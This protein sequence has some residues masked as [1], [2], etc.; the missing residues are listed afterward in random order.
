MIDAYSRCINLREVA[1]RSNRA[2]LPSLLLLSLRCHCSHHS[3]LHPL[4]Q[5]L[6]HLHHSGRSQSPPPANVHLRGPYLRAPPRPQRPRRHHVRQTPLRASGAGAGGLQGPQ[7]VS[8]CL[9]WNPSIE[10]T[11][12]HS[13]PLCY[14]PLEQ[15]R[16]RHF[17]LSQWCPA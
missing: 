11:F 13:P 1:G 10:D 8:T 17:N 4:V 7:N 16:G 2:A 15:F 9:Q 3:Q 14:I 5:S 6:P 12:H